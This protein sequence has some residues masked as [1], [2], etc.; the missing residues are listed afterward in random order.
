ML[1]RT[2]ASIAGGVL[3]LFLLAAALWGQSYQGG[4]RGIVSDASGGAVANAKITLTDEAAGVSRATISNSSGEFVFTS[5]EPATYLVTV[6]APGFKKFDRKG[7]VVAT[8]Q[9]L[10]LDVR[11]EVGQITETVQVLEE[12]PLLESSN[13][14]NGQVLDRQKMVDLPNL[15]R[16]PFL[17]SKLAANVVPV[18]DP[19]F[20][21]FQ[22]QSGS[23]QISIAGGPV[24]GNNYLIDGVPITDSVNRA[25]IIPSIEAVQEMKLQAN[26]YDAEMG[27]TG[28][29]VFN[30]YL[31][32][33]T[34]DWHGSALGYTRQTDW[35]AN[36]FF[37]NR[38]GTPRP[39]TPFYNYGASFG[40]P[41]RIPRLYNGRNR[42]FFW[43]VAEGYRQKSN[44][45]A[46]QAVPTA[47]ER[48][49][50]FS[51]SSVTI[52][53]PLSGRDRQPFPGNRI[54]ASRLDPVGLKAA[55]YFPLPQRAA[56]SYGSTNRTGQDTLTDRSDEYTS[57][58]DHEFTSWWRANAS[59]LHYKS[60]E[61]SGNLFGNLVGSQS[62]LLFRKVD[63]TQVNNIL[64]PSPTTVVSIRYGFN[65]FPNDTREVSAGFNPALL[66]F[67]PYYVNNIQTLA[68]P[69]F[70]FQ[71]M[72]ELG[73]SSTSAGVYYSKNF[74]AS[75][76]RF[77]G[78]HSLKAGFDYRGLNV[79]FIDLGTAAGQFQ[80]DDTF[81]R[82]DPTRPGAGTGADVASLLLGY[83]SGG[84]V[85][86]ST[87]FFTFVR[88][89]AG[90]IHDDFR[91]ASK[92]TLNLGLRYEYASGIAERNNNYV[93]GFDRTAASPLGPPAKGALLFAGVG[94]NPTACCN[95]QKAAFAPRIGA[96]YSWNSKTVIRGGYGLFYA[97]TRFSFDSGLAPGYT[98]ITPYVASNDGGY[99]PAASLSDPFPNGILKPAGNALGARTGIGSS[100]NFLDQARKTGVVHQFSLDVQR[101][102]PGHIVVEA[103][104]VGSRSNHLQPSSTGSGLININQVPPQFLS[105]GDSLRDAVP[106]PFYGNGGAGIVGNPTVS[107]AQLLKPYPQYSSVN[108][109]TDVSSARYDAMVLKAQK[110]LTRGLTFLATYTW[111]KNLDKSFGSSNN[112]N[113]SG[114][115]PQDFYNLA[116]EYSLAIV[117]TPSRFTSNLSYELPFG[118]GK[119]FLHHPGPLQYLVGGWQLNFL[120]IYQSGFPLAILQSTNFNSVVGAGLQRPNATGVSPETSGKLEDRIDSYI[121][122]AAFSPAILGA[123]GN[124]SRTI[125]YRGPGQANWDVSVFK[126]FAIAERL[127][128][129]FRAEALNALNTPLFRSPN[130]SFGSSRF[131]KITTQAN[132][133][134]YIQ[135]GFRVYF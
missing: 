67:P 122:K 30:A 16:N 112:L 5:V 109:A 49:G 70:Q 37:N 15:G 56:R 45:S 2:Y 84:L 110:R 33:G 124:V 23:S 83:P 78:R 60:R 32:S 61:P 59:Y 71:N 111:S 7:V 105:L 79:D 116:A 87:K 11:L 31:R 42:T 104:Y 102:L 123:F 91:L 38:S 47:L 106:N 69:D 76:A 10:T 20:N 19:R 29:G 34:N 103:G 96:A 114:S 73:G 25:V 26:T 18:G 57:K 48:T 93:V 133:P 63:A 92:L 108:A 36:D 118:K 131:G 75:V 39:D 89:Y 51:Q 54:P 135:L 90:Y 94:G 44:L 74:L 43:V 98:Q 27:R 95:P 68:F 6:E 28:G 21:R 115:A 24:R 80:F 82:K 121:N 81:T 9:F 62:N 72:T 86:T 100:I 1:V 130:G 22:D 64:T 101:E 41:V 53:D 65:R 117:N 97:P 12:V 127:H 14:S 132:F 3:L 52:Y 58:V 85:Q 50:D 4:L 40:G 66:G 128:A 17:L 35:L 113:S 46:E 55:S 129:Q 126:D 120:T 88:Y 13:A 134:R 125:P 8:Q 77:M 119:A 107:R 99:T